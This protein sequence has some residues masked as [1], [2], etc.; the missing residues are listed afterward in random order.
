MCDPVDPVV[1]PVD[2]VPDAAQ[3]DAEDDTGNGEPP[4]R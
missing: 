4:P 2:P 3:T 1:P